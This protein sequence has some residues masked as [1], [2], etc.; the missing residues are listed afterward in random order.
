MRPARIEAITF[1]VGGT[2]IEPWPSVGHVYATVAAEFGVEV[3]PE[4]LTTGF[5]RAWK[6]R[7]EFDYSRAAWFAL[8]RAT[9]GSRAAE[10]PEEFFPGVYDRFVAPEVWRIFEDVAPTLAGLKAQGIRLAVISNWDERLYPM[11]ERLGLAEPFELVM[12]SHQAGVTK[13]SPEIF[14]RTAEELRLAPRTVLH[15]GD[16]EREDVAGAQAA[17]F[18]AAQIDR[19]ASMKRLPGALQSLTELLARV[20]V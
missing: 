14:R 19:N 5:V 9:F 4:E 8:V 7:G 10:L 20:G 3:S 17:G 16:S 2:L 1:D 18:A 6:A 15:V 12:S 11:L 13:P